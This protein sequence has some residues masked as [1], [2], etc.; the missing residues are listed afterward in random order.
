MPTLPPHQARDAAESFGNDPERYDRTRPGYP[1]ELVRRITG[2]VLDVGCGTG[3]LARQL[4]ANGCQ[5]LGVDVDARMA[6]FARERGLDV[7]VAKFEEWDARGRTFDVV[8]SGQAW[9]WVDPEAGAAR[10]VQ[11]LDPG[12]RLALFWNVVQ[13]PQDLTR[14]MAEM[15]PTPMAEMSARSAMDGY[16]V[17]FATAAEGIR[18][19]ERFSTPEEWRSEW[20]RHYTRDEWLEHLRTSGGLARLRP[21]QVEELLTG[22]GA[23]IG[24][25]FTAHYTTVV[26]TAEV[27]ASHRAPT[28]RPGRG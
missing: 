17:M 18:R 27:S 28:S 22:V 7:E 9:H 12:G 21:A 6:G 1:E 24:E 26:V 4:Q 14:T 10:A 2:T 15:L 5:V 23:A 3:I 19:A 20:E 8:V 13:P 11:L 16:A 25:G